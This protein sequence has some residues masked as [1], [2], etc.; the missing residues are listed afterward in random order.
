MKLVLSGISLLGPKILPLI[1]LGPSVNI[2]PMANTL[3]YGL[4]RGGV[5]ALKNSVF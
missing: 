1:G 4:N 3:S 2:F 5:G